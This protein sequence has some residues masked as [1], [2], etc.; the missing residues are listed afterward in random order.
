[1]E[2]SLPQKMTPR[3]LRWLIRRYNSGRI[4]HGSCLLAAAAAFWML[5]LYFIIVF[6]KMALPESLAVYR[7]EMPWGSVN[8]VFM[9]IVGG[10]LSLIVWVGFFHWE[11]FFAVRTDP[12]LRAIRCVST[13]EWLNPSWTTLFLSVVCLAPILTCLAAAVF[14]QRLTVGPAR[15]YL[16]VTLFDYL[17]DWGDWV[18]YPKFE[19]QRQAM[20]LLVRLDL[21]RV[22]RRFG[23]HQVKLVGGMP[24]WRKKTHL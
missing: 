20:I 23:K 11:L 12:D 24:H 3:K 17:D 21:I 19:S 10:L 8:P 4:L 15:L 16:A 9:V 2:T 6:V 14:R 7:W 22:S 18:S 5:T 13:M 1:M